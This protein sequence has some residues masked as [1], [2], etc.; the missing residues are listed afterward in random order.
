M[1]PRL[2]RLLL[3]VLRDRRGGTKVFRDEL[4]EKSRHKES[5]PYLIFNLV[6]PEVFVSLQ[7]FH[8]LQRGS[9]SADVDSSGLHFLPRHLFLSHHMVSFTSREA[10]VHLHFSSLPIDLRIIVLEPGVAKDHALPPEVG[11]GKEHSLR[12]DLIMENYI[13]HFR[14]LPCFVRRA[15]HI[16][17]QY[18]ARDVPDANTLR[19]D[20]VSVYEAAHSPGV[21]K[22]LDRIHL[23]S[24]S[25]TDLNRKDDRH[26]AGIKD[27]SGESSG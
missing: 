6:T 15:I 24:V 16:E 17:H 2:D 7:V 12:V 9:G 1:F 13:Y 14:D 25:G 19:T 18:R 5:V 22:H 21:Q 10:P 23:A 11:D 4:R 26:S 3:Q 27:I 20:K 8:I